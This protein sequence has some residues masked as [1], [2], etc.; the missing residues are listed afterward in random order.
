MDLGWTCGGS[1]TLLA[2]TTDPAIRDVSSIVC[3]SSA[4]CSEIRER[5]VTFALDLL[6][7]LLV[8][9]PASSPRAIGTPP[10]A[11]TP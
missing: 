6:R 8:V 11:R 4:T 1:T 5:S 3:C 10:E 9:L 2:A 7:R